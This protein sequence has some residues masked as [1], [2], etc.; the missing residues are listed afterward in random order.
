MWITPS[1]LRGSSIF[2]P[3]GGCGFCIV[4]PQ[5]VCRLILPC[6][7]PQLL[8]HIPQPAVEKSKLQTAIDIGG[9]IPQVILQGGILIFQRD[10]HLADVIKHRGV[11]LAEFLADI[12]QT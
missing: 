9:D 1:L 8:F 7:F 2:Y 6:S 11:I 4:F 10:L 5:A 3:Q 12:R